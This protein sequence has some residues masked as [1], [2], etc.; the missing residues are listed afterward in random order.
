MDPDDKPSELQ[1]LMEK[2]V[3]AQ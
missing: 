2:H 1:E 3:A